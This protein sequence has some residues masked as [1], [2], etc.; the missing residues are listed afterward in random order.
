MSQRERMLG[1]RIPPTPV[2]IRVDF[3][4]DADA[5]FAAHEAA[6]RDLE[7]AGSRG[8]D[9]DAARARVAATKADLDPFQEVLYVSALP[10]S[11]Y[12]ELIGEHPPTDEQRTRNYQW[13]PETFAPALLAACIGQELPDEERMS[14]KDWIDWA[15]LGAASVNGEF[16]TLVN[17]CLAVNDRAINVNVGKG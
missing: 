4:P 16:V 17:T 10:P 12:D 1:R 11:V 5:A 7:T 6:S 13:N 14:E 15:S 3:G 8:A 9:L 2:A